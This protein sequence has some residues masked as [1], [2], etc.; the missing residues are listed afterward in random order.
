MYLVDIDHFTCNPSHSLT[1]SHSLPHLPLPL[2][3]SKPLTPLS[4]HLL[5]SSSSY[6]L[7]PSP[8]HLLILLPSHLLTPLT[9]SLPSSPYPLTPLPLHS[10]TSLPPRPL[11]LS[12]QHDLPSHSSP[13]L[14]EKSLL[15]TRM[16]MYYEKR[17]PDDLDLL[18]LFLDIVLYVYK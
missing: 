1:L 16:M 15:L 7:T 9:S 11:T 18:T 12:P 6:P 10:L 8:L 14:R 3:T 5:T 13:S 17:F 2:Y 4:P